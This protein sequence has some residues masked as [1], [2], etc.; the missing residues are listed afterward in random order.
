[1]IKKTDF[2]NGRRMHWQGAF[3]DRS[4]GLGWCT[5][6]DL[7]VQEDVL[8]AEAAGVVWSPE[9]ELLPEK[10]ELTG[11][12]VRNVKTGETLGYFYEQFAREAVEV[13]HRW[14][15]WPE[16]QKLARVFLPRCGEDGLREYIRRFQ[17]ILDSEEEV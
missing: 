1:M 9:K 6:V 11:K 7:K 12:Q 15:A 3:A 16:L 14:N 4:S 10:L 13:V 5:A 17:A 8:A 2:E